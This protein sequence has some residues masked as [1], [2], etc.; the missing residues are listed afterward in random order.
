VLIDSWLSVSVSHGVTGRLR[1]RRAALLTLLVWLATSA[2]QAQPLVVATT[3]D[4]KSITEA[5]AGGTV[6]VESLV[7]PGT[8]P[9]AFEARPSHLSMVREASLVVRVGAGFDE[10]LD[11]LLKQSRNAG[12]QRGTSGHLDLSTEIALLEVQ[13]RSVEASSGH[14]HGAANPH[15]WLDPANAEIMSAQIAEALTR[16]A[17]DGRE[18]IAAAQ[19]RFATDLKAGLAR[20]TAALAADRGAAVIAYHNSWPY[21]ARR[22]R[23]NIVDVIEAKEGVP[24]SAARLAKLAAQMREAKVRAVLH[25]PFVPSEASRFLAERSGAR[26]VVLAPSVGSKPEAGDYLALFDHNVE[27]L[28]AA[29][30][31]SR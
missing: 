25:E 30:A 9:E 7:P 3:P 27:V 10:W 16:I 15:Y 22:F 19:K 6:R 29:L 17:P 11:R 1:R 18:V 24:P 4:L 20:W 8:D 21:F 31:E 14:A 28:A 12:V 2:T 5:V 23:L 26:L 13:G